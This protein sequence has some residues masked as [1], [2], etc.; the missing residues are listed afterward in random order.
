MLLKINRLV[1]GDIFVNYLFIIFLL[2]FFWLKKNLIIFF[3]GGGGGCNMFMFVYLLIKG[4]L[5]V[6]VLKI[7]I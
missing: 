1:N 5:G 4:I 3:F 6:C 7:I 2:I